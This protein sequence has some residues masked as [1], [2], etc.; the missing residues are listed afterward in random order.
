MIPFPTLGT[1]PCWIESPFTV[2]PRPVLSGLCSR[3]TGCRRFCVVRPDAVSVWSLLPSGD[4]LFDINC[5]RSRLHLRRWPAR[6]SYLTVS[7]R[8]RLQ[9]QEE[10]QTDVENKQ[11]E[12]WARPDSNWGPPACESRSPIRWSSCNALF[13]ATSINWG[14][15]CQG[16]REIR[17]LWRSKNRPVWRRSSGF[18]GTAGTEPEGAL[19]GDLRRSGRRPTKTGASGGWVSRKSEIVSFDFV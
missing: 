2:R 16:R 13:P 7:L 6:A 17:P 14:N 19:Q 8:F 3:T 9:Q 10:R 18:R 4:L 5:L 15:L 1:I 12:W 11:V